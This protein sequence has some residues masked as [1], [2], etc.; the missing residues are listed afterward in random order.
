MLLNPYSRR[1]QGVTEEKTCETKQAN[2]GNLSV[3]LLHCIIIY[4]VSIAVRTNPYLVVNHVATIIY[5]NKS[6]RGTGEGQERASHS[7]QYSQSFVR[8]NHPASKWG[9]IR[10]EKNWKPSL[11]PYLLDGLF[12]DWLVWHCFSGVKTTLPDISP[13]DVYSLLEAWTQSSYT[14][15]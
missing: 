4:R 15:Y 12:V 11:R 5:D 8:W 10:K 1:W 3:S 7:P 2:L 14:S 6:L 9:S 13:W